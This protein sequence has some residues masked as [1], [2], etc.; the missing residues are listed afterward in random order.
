LFWMVL[1][2]FKNSQELWQ[3]PPTIWPHNPTISGFITVFS[4]MPFARYL[5]NSVVVAVL[6]TLLSV[7]TSSLAG[8]VFSKLKFRG[9]DILFI[10]VLASMM[11]PSQVLV[12]PRYMLVRWLGWL[13]TYWGLVLPQGITVFGIF[14]VRQFLHSVPNDYLDAARI[15]GLSEFGI[16]LRIVLPLSTPVLASLAIFAFKGAWDNL[17]WPLVIIT[18][19]EMRTLPMGIAGL[20]TVHSPE[21]HLLLPAATISSLPILIVFL[22]CQRQII[23]AFV[24]SGLKG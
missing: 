8:Y 24:M 3:F 13:N 9:R 16:Y 19:P 4:K 21:W 18:K 12:I 10:L 22:F 11:I 20:A 2:S 14:M 23:E 1:S 6:V 7:F 5:F 15:D 17:L